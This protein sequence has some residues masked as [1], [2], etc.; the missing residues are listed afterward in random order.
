MTVQ[1]PP[2]LFTP[3][4][5][6]TSAGTLYTVPNTPATIALRNVRLRFTNLT[7]SAHAVTAYAVPSGSSPATGN[8]VI[9]A[10]SIAG[11]AHM[12]VDMPSLGAGGS[13]SAFADTLTSINASELSAVLF[14]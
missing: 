4:T 5:L 11:N 13:Y 8:I 7:T 2:P 6:T 14:S 12:D 3:T 10:E 1:V 9:N